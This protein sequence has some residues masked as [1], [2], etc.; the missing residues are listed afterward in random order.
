MFFFFLYFFLFLWTKKI[1]KDDFIFFLKDA[2]QQEI[3]FKNFDE[4]NNTNLKS[5]QKFT[6]DK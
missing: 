6:L 2:H 3:T 5:N 1:L 4:E